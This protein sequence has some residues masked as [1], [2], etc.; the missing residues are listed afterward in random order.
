MVRYV[1]QR[2]DEERMGDDRDPEIYQLA[3]GKFVPNSDLPVLIYRR[4]LPQPWNAASAKQLCERN[5]WQKRV[6]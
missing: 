4:V 6:T 5:H 3:R 2:T 1:L